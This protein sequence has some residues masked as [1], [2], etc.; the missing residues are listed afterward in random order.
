MLLF[1]CHPSSGCFPGGSM[2]NFSRRCAYVL[3]CGSLCTGD[4]CRRAFSFLFVLYSDSPSPL[5]SCSVFD[6]RSRALGQLCD[7]GPPI[8]D[9][10]FLVLRF[11]IG[12]LRFMS[13]SWRTSGTWRIK[14]RGKL[15]INPLFSRKKERERTQPSLITFLIEAGGCM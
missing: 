2:N 7:L 15:L 3:A 10:R 6:F 14:F 8:F 11:S 5:L 12:D 9:F 1:A 13:G 4:T